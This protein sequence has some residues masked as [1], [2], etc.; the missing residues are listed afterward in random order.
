MPALK[1]LLRNEGEKYNAAA[2]FPCTHNIANGF[3][4][5]SR[6][7][8][9]YISAFAYHAIKES[10]REVVIN[11]FLRTSKGV[12]ETNEGAAFLIYAVQVYRQYAQVDYCKET[13]GNYGME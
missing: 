5:Q 11:I 13:T 3:N 1:H 4:E 12:S 9:V 8:I 6:R 2:D 10:E 7:S